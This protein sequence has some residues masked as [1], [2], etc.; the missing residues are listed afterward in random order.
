MIVLILNFNLAYSFW[1]PIERNNDQ[2]NK[3]YLQ[4]NYEQSLSA[5]LKAQKDD[6]ENPILY[7]NIGNVHYQ[8][9]DYAIAISNY[10]K[11]LYNGGINL[12]SLSYYNQGNCYF[13]LKQYDKA[14]LA[15][16]KSLEL[17]D[18]DLD[19]KQNLEIARKKLLEHSRRQK[20]HQQ[21]RVQDKKTKNKKQK[22]SGKQQQKANEKGQE[23]QGNEKKG[24]QSGQNPQKQ[25]QQKKGGKENSLSQENKKGNS[26]KNKRSAVA[27]SVGKISKK[28]AQK[29]LQSVE[30][31]Q[32]QKGVYNFQFQQPASKGRT[33]KEW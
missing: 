5:Y 8:K 17:N 19:A 32:K 18:K 29:I 31:K 7:Y 33:F 24:Q 1:N 28:D 23:G 13:N 25:S 22:S 3:Y 26:E 11:A 20:S 30:N 27:K 10:D 6:P 12:Q 4:K 16:K 15:Y 14:V 2:G 9:K 21:D